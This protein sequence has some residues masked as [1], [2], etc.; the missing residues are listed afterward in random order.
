M[1]NSNDVTVIQRRITKQAINQKTVTTLRIIKQRI[2][3]L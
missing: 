1:E 3:I 2:V